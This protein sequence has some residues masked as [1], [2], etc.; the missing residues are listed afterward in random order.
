MGH[1][2]TRISRK[3]IIAALRH[4]LDTVDGLDGCTV[5][6][7]TSVHAYIEIWISGDAGESAVRDAIAEKLG[8]PFWIN[9][10]MADATYT[11]VAVHPGR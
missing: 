6:M 10:G 11:V 3:A 7:D 1:G 8:I 9:L 2:T 4:E 5:V